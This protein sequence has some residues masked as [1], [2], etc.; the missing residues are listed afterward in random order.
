MP[1][2][3]EIFGQSSPQK[4]SRGNEIET[5][6]ANSFIL[7]L[8][9]LSD[10]EWYIEIRKSNINWTNPQIDEEKKVPNLIPTWKSAKSSDSGESR[11]RTSFASS[12]EY[13]GITSLASFSP[14]HA[15]LKSWL[16]L[17][18]RT[19]WQLGHLNVIL[20]WEFTI[21]TIHGTI[22]LPQSYQT[23]KSIALSFINITQHW[24]KWRT[25]KNTIYVYQ[26]LLIN[27]YMGVSKTTTHVNFSLSIQENRTIVIKLEARNRQ[28]FIIR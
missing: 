5:K 13:E 4:V 18:K 12:S 19:V 24:K 15:S 1:Y 10:F 8:R 14:S 2:L 16:Y 3:K 26:V 20:H 27:G 22:V 23:K 21:W 9:A 28:K 25:N 11:G 17:P 6:Q 7:Q